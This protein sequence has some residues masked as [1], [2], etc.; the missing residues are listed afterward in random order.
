MVV[1]GVKLFENVCCISMMWMI[2]CFVGVIGIGY[3]GMVYFFVY[4]EKV[5]I[6][7]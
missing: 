6:V 5:S 3:F 1:E 7:S 2:I 4:L